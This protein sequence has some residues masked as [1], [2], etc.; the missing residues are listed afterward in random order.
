LQEDL[1]KLMEKSAADDVKTKEEATQKS[2][3]AE[4]ATEAK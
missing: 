4:K 3:K 1:D 2:E